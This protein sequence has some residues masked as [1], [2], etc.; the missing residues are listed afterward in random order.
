M[1]RYQLELGGSSLT[2]I[3]WKVDMGPAACWQDLVF[4]ALLLLLLLGT[5]LVIRSIEL[6]TVFLTYVRLINCFHFF[7]S[8]AS[9]FSS[10]Y[11]LLF[12]KPARSCVLLLFPTH[13]TSVSLSP[14]RENNNVV[15]FPILFH[16]F[17]SLA[18]LWLI[19][20]HGQFPKQQITYKISTLLL[21]FI[22]WLLNV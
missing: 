22:S 9:S 17:M 5:L 12:L 6:W 8:S 10:Q 20:F 2:S 13:F 7:Q 18:N 11:L 15:V 16:I 4:N 1:D 21:V 14:F 19:R 3:C